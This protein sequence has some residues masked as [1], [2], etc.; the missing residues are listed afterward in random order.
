MA[1]VIQNPEFAE[2]WLRAKKLRAH[3]AAERTLDVAENATP[4]TVA[5]DRL[6]VDVYRWHASKL[7]TQAYG[8]KVAETHISTTTNNFVVLTSAKL[9]ELQGRKAMALRAA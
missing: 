6:K 3:W 8:E 1:W 2:R 7:D 4:E 5:V 9:Q